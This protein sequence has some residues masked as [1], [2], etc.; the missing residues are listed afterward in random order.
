[1]SARGRQ[2][3]LSEKPKKSKEKKGKRGQASFFIAVSEEKDK[4][5]SSVKIELVV[6]FFHKYP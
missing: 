5:A 1:M 6:A 3:G 2:S 4:F